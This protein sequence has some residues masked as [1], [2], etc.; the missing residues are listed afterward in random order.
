MIV[1]GI[2]LL[3]L[4]YLLPD[5]LPDVPYGILH[6]CSVLGTVALIIGIVL[7]ILGVAGRP[8]GRGWGGRGYWF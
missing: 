1:L 2:V 8:V 7:L 3:L 4:A 6:I 5:M